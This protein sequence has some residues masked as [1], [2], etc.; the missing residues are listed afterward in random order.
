M[1]TVRTSGTI[2]FKTKNNDNSHNVLVSKVLR[3]MDEIIE[4]ISTKAEMVVLIA[5]SN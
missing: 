2:T 3:M 5:I 4:L 1:N